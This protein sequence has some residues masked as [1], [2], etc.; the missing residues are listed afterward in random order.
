MT[1]LEA[2]LCEEL[3]I[4]IPICQR[5]FEH[6]AN[7]LGCTEEAIVASI[8]RLREQGIIRRFGPIINHRTMGR[9]STLVMGHLPEQ[10][11]GSAAELINKLPH[12]SHNYIRDHHYNLWFTLHANTQQQ[13]QAM[14]GQLAGLLGI[15]LYSLPTIRVLKLQVYFPI[16]GQGERHVHPSVATTGRQIPNLLQS[17]ILERMLPDIPI[18]PRPFALLAEGLAAEQEVIEAVAGLVAKGIVRRI[19]AILD[20]YALGLCANALLAAQVQP[21]K[22]ESAIGP[23][24]SSRLVS[25]L[26]LRKQVEAWPYNLYAMI[27]ASDM[28]QIYLL[29]GAFAEQ[30]GNCE[31]QLLRTVRQVKKAP[32]PYRLPEDIGLV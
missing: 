26:V 6:M 11:L 4:G 22:V 3:Q 25:H 1:E 10:I 12:V 5:P 31:Y 30:A 2:R 29:V 9:Y 19:S 16:T 7:M 20:H 18:H 14:I 28:E 15:G 23:L 24:A 32:S 13:A 8:N 17:Q 21:D 27:H